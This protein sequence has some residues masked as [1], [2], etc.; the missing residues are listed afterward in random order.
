MKLTWRRKREGPR[1]LTAVTPRG[2]FW[3]RHT[4]HGETGACTLLYLAHQVGATWRELG[5]CRSQAEAKDA[6]FRH[7]RSA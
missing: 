4:G 6:A 5:P 3:I 2:R 1:D 7:A